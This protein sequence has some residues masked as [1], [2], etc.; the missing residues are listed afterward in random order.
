MTGD[1]IET[2][3]FDVN[4]QTSNIT[5][6]LWPGFMMSDIAAGAYLFVHDLPCI[7]VTG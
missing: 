1:V 5:L 2:E 4:V 6:T 3:S 7:W